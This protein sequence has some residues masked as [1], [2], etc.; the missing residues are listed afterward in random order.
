LKTCKKCILY[1]GIKGIVIGADGLCNYCHWDKEMNKDYPID[2]VS[3]D[4]LIDTIK[5]KGKGHLYDVVIGLSGGCDSSYLL[6]MMVESGVRCL[7]IHFD[8]N[9]NTDIAKENMDVLTNCFGVDLHIRHVGKEMYD[10]LCKSFLLASTPD[11]D[12]PNDI[13]L[14]VV[15]YQEAEVN[16]IPTILDGHSFRT[17]GTCP[18]G[19]TYMDGKYIDS[20]NKRFLNIDI[21]TYPNMLLRDWLR[22]ISIP[23]LRPLYYIDYNKE[24]AKNELSEIGWNDY[25]GHHRENRYTMFVGSYLWKNKFHQDLRYVALSAQIRNKHITRV[26]A[27]EVLKEPVF[28]PMELLFEVR[29]RLNFTCDAFECMM[30]S[31]VKTHE[32]YDTYDFSKLGQIFD[33]YRDVLPKTFIDKYVDKKV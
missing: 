28:C 29:K 25:G 14:A 17:E 2:A 19:W 4:R 18:V 22:W 15:A 1:D 16:D 23:R 5:N 20:V 7:G 8:N 31:P 13:A 30:K 11:A 3:F 6:K 24:K 12:I 33:E 21:S 26:K 27:L 9:W 32:D 10:G